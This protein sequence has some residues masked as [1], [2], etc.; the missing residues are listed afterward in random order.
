M[1]LEEYLTLDELHVISA[2]D[3][4]SLNACLAIRSAE[5]IPITH[6]AAVID[7]L[8]I[9]LNINSVDENDRNCLELL[10]ANLQGQV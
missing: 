3:T 4:Q 5:S 1:T 7:Y 8:L 10:L 9:A 2:G 6:R